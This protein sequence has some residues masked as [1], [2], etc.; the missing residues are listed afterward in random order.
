MWITGQQPIRKWININKRVPSWIYVLGCTASVYNGGKWVN[1]CCIDWYDPETKGLDWHNQIFINQT[2]GD[3]FFFF[4]DV[5]VLFYMSSKFIVVVDILGCNF[6][7]TDL[8]L[9]LYICTTALGEACFVEIWRSLRLF[10]WPDK[11]SCK[12]SFLCR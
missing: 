9:H 10:M 8:I 3:V 6:I 2:K 5:I 1:R 11:D 7:V 12:P 4:F